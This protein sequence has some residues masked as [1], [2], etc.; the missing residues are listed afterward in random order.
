MKTKF[1]N[2]LG[3]TAGFAVV[4][5]LAI[6]LAAVT[7]LLGQPVAG[8]IWTTDPT[9]SGVDLN[10]YASK[11]AVYLNGGPAHGTHLPAGDYYVK[12][13]DPS[14]ACILGASEP[15]LPF[16][17]NADGSTNCIKLCEV[18][19]NGD[20]TCALNGESDP[21]CGYNTTANPGGEYKVWVSMDATFPDNSSKTD[22]FKVREDAPPNPPNL[23]VYKFYDANVNGVKDPTECYINGWPF[24]VFADNN[25]YV[26]STTSWCGLVDEDSYRVAEGDIANW[27][28]TGV[29][30]N[31]V[32]FTGTGSPSEVYPV[33]LP[34]DQTLEFGNVCLGAGGGLTLGF[35]SNKNGQKIETAGDF[36]MLTNLCLRNATGGN[37]DFNTG[38]L[39]QKKA[40]LNTWLLGGTAVNMAYMLSVQLAAMELNVAHYSANPAFGVNGS[41][42]VYA[43][44]LLNYAPIQGL[45]T[46]G[47]ISI[48]DLMTAANAELCL[49]GNTPS[50]SPYRAYQE[51]M[52]TTL[53]NG[54]NNTNFVQ[55]QPCSPFTCAQ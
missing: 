17:V 38:T 5:V 34:P 7:A 18:L 2:I 14:G 12:V 50:D 54:N 10:I 3:G 32:P 19:V 44:C 13:T 33:T 55:S 35:W 25:L 23:C 49:H 29:A 11:D 37:Q 48:N 16:H 42:L 24:Q 51:C 36:A 39:D 28:H 21:A 8:A 52:K 43:P 40:A 9:C 20:P 6:L 4:T 15:N 31:G 47:F 53:D 27:V 1:A 46:H 41:A 30:V 22:N 26:E 45:D